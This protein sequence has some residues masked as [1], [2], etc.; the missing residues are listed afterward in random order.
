MPHAPQAETALIGASTQSRDAHAAALAELPG[1]AGEFFNDV[2]R[3]VFAALTRL[4]AD[5]V[6]VNP[7]TLR[8][9]IGASVGGQDLLNFLADCLMAVS[10]AAHAPDY[11]REVH[12]AYLCRQYMAQFA[13]LAAAAGNG[14]TPSQIAA[15]ARLRLDPLYAASAGGARAVETGGPVLLRLADVDATPVSW[16]WPGRIAIGKLTLIAGDPGL[17]KSFLTLDIAARLSRGVAWPDGAPGNGCGGTVLLSAEDDPG[18]TIR[19]RLDAANADLERI[20]LLSAV[21]GRDAT[22]GMAERPV[23]LAADLA[24]V[25]RAIDGVPDC[26]LFVVDPVSAYLGETDSHVN[27]EVRA[28]LAPLSKL[29]ARKGVALIAVTHLRKGDGPAVYRAIGSLAFVAAARAAWAVAKDPDDEGGRRRL[30]LPMKS[31]IAPDATGLAY[32]LRTG[33]NGAAVVAW[34]AS[35]VTLPADDALAPRRQSG[36]DGAIEEAVAWLRE[37]LADG[38]QPGIDVKAGAK[39]DGIAPRTL[40]RAKYRLGVVAAPDGYRGPW[41]WRL[42]HGGADCHSSPDSPQCA[43]SESLAHSGAIGALC[44]DAGDGGD[45]VREWTG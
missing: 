26:K 11:A 22:G 31:N 37:R 38:P 10:A 34:G 29:A 4:H 3:D 32:E 9:Y 19:P 2:R 36:G 35:A 23:N 44:G 21:R 15:E 40:D 45:G 14:A 6:D 16:L 42:P 1:G 13:K 17:G 27:A 8:E 39:A 43:I 28:V 5:G 20:A 12:R 30:F 25:E 33:L 7:A 41:V 18:D 24:D